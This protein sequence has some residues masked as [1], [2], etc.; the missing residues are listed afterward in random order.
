MKLKRDLLIGVTFLVLIALLGV[1]QKLL[2]TRAVAEA[3]GV[4]RK[5]VV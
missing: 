2:E 5:S 3:A 4:D 1:G